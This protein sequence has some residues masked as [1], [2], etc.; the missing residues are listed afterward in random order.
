MNAEKEKHK[1]IVIAALLAICCALTYY[2]HA[3]L[4]TGAVFTHF[5]YIPIILACLWWKRKGV[6]VAI[7][8]AALL[9]FSNNLRV[10]PLTGNDY[11][12]ALMLIAIGTVVAI[13][14]EKITKVQARVN[15]LNAV[16]SSIRN[17]NQLIVMQKDRDSLIQGT[18]KS[19]TTTRGYYNAW[20]V[21]LDESG[22]V[23][24]TAESGLGEA[25]LSV[26]ERFRRGELTA[27][28][29][30]ALTHSGPVVTEV[31]SAICTGC[32]LSTKYSGKGAISM[33]LEYGDEIYGILSAGIPAEFIADE[34]EH[35]LFKELAYD[36]ALALHNIKQA[37][38]R[39]ILDEDR[40]KLLQAVETTKEAIVITTPDIMISYANNAAY[41][42]FGYE[43]EELIGKSV[44]ILSATTSEK[45]KELKNLITDTVKKE[46]VW[47]GELVNRKKSGTEFFSYAK[48]SALKDE[49]GKIIHYV[50]AMHDITEQKRAEVAL[51]GFSEEMEL[52]V[53]ARTEELKKERDYVRHLIESSPDFQLTLDKEGTILDVNNAF[54][55]LTGKNRKDLIG[56]PIYKYIEKKRINKLV[57]EIANNG[58][59]RDKEFLLEMPDKKTLIINISG[60]VFTT[61]EGEEGVYITGRDL[62]EAKA[63]ETQLIHAGRLSSLGE[64]ASGI[65]HEINQPLSLISL[66]TGGLLRDVEKNRLDINRFPE[67]IEEILNS[68]KRIDKII[69][70]M[71]AFSRKQDEIVVTKPEEVLN[72]VFTLLGA[73]LKMHNISVSYNREDNLPAILVNPN[74]LEQVFVNIMTNARQVLDEQEE[75]AKRSGAASFKKQLVCEI[76][77]E[78]EKG[79]EKVVYVF[80]DNG[81]GVPDELKTRVF[82]PF[83]T[84]KNAGEGTGLGLS[85]AYRIMTEALKGSIWVEDNDMGGASFKVALPAADTEEKREERASDYI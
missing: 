17:V 77:R 3:V 1:I 65:A 49:T 33:R 56:S 41:G 9:I 84:T 43:K 14:S 23:M 59:I 51:R 69:R 22:G 11:L 53:E 28:G 40:N 85:I 72:N 36:V 46:G 61:E 71:R 6:V 62:T 7:F 2:F 38:E 80:A 31:P 82:E 26:E 44:S 24:A 37:E 66:T 25:F 10:P 60:T 32:P 74:Q 5:F 78:R 58:K 63:K 29:Q 4:E 57:T 68:V 34:E 55:Q 42:L 81:Y 16:L 30:R 73:Q 45:N 12:R 70:H 54:E 27:C 39:K 20:I 83:F 76:S 21:L 8:L 15:H 50:S 35:Q 79:K 47:E 13:L 18:C 75:I 64:M 48:I 19:L 67:D 52:K